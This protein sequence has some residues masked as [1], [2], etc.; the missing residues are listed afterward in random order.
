MMTIVHVW[1][2][3]GECFNPSFAVQRYPPLKRDNARFHRAIVY[4]TRL[5]L[6]LIHGTMTTQR[7]VRDILKPHIAMARLPGAIFQQ[8]NACLH[9]A[10]VSQICLHHISTLSWP[11]SSPDLPPIEHIWDNLGQPTRFVELETRLQLWGTRC[12]WT[13]YGTCIPQCPT[14]SHHAFMLEMTPIPSFAIFSAQ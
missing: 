1:G 2:G 14:I 9:T 10:R 7:Y 3:H 11:A 5:L 12:R 8:D 13:S 6:I 4:D